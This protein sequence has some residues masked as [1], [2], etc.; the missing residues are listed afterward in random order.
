MGV[1]HFLNVNEGDCIL[2]QHPS[3][4]NSVIDIS[5]GAI[6]EN[7]ES[8][9]FKIIVTAKDGNKESYIVKVKREPYIKIDIDEPNPEPFDNGG[10]YIDDPEEQTVTIIYDYKKWGEK[11]DSEKLKAGTETHKI[12]IRG[13][14]TKIF[15]KRWKENAAAFTL[16]YD[17]NHDRYSLTLP[18]SEL[19]IGFTGQPDFAFYVDGNP[20]NVN[21]VDFIDSKY[22]FYPDENKIMI[23]F[24]NE[25]EER[26]AK[27]AENKEKFSAIKKLAEFDISKKQDRADIT[28]LRLVPGT[29]T[30]RV[31]IE[32]I[33]KLIKELGIKSDINLCEDKTPTVGNPYT[34]YGDNGIDKVTYQ[35]EVPEYYQNILD[36]NNVFYVGDKNFGGNGIIPS[37]E[38]VYYYSDSEYMLQWLKQIFDFINCCDSSI[39]IS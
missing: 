2:I 16:H 34:I 8:V 33:Q 22:L 35:I 36:N 3:G 38:H 15:D 9:E 25:S 12:V 26:L 14:F 28:N 23:L 20:R 32:E 31:R 39:I 10:I 24:K 1:I 13:S 4:H 7:G 21:S 29:P 5:N 18:Y 6:V 27:I 37:A 19:R 11:W 30:E 17:E